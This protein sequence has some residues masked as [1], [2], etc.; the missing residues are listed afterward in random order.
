MSASSE[1]VPGN[2]VD[3]VVSGK[4]GWEEEGQEVVPSCFLR[5]APLSYRKIRLGKKKE[6]IGWVYH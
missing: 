1:G 6:K 3:G 5:G 2:V 4:T